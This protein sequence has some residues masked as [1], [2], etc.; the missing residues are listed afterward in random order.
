MEKTI[1]THRIKVSS[2]SAELPGQ[3][4]AEKRTTVKIEV[5]IYE[6]SYRDNQDGTH[7]LIYK[8]KLVG[9]T[10]VD[11]LGMKE[12]YICKSK[13]TPSQRL[14]AKLFTINP[15][16]EYYELIL[17]KLLNNAEAVCDFLKDK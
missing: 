2:F 15:S 10:I 17:E 14:R 7:D 13:R 5:D 1:N 16:D 8:S 3:L 9:S 4:D 6:T 12:K 11:Q